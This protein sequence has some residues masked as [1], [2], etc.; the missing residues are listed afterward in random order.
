MRNWTL[1]DNV[2]AIHIMPLHLGTA[3]H[4]PRSMHPRRVF[5]AHATPTFMHTFIIRFSLIG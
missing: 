4:V 2:M 5:Q 3:A 1:I